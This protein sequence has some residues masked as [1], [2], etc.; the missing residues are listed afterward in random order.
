MFAHLVWVYL[1]LGRIA[2]AI[3]IAISI[4]NSIAV[5]IS[6]PMAPAIMPVHVV[7]VLRFLV[8]N[9]RRMDLR[10]RLR[11]LLSGHH[12]RR[13]R[14]MVMMMR[15]I[16][17]SKRGRRRSRISPTPSLTSAAQTS[18]SATRSRG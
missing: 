11:R 3:A 15:V 14:V 18:H 5:S 4:V 6:L 16:I 10:T 17:S 7:H 9:E 2:I 1:A 8:L 13:S 12:R